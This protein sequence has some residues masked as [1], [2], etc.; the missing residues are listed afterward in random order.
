[1]KPNPVMFAHAMLLIAILACNL[2]GSQSPPSPEDKSQPEVD[3]ESASDLTGLWVGTFNETV[4][5]LRSLNATLEIQPGSGS[6]ITGTFSL[7]HPEGHVLESYTVNGIVEGNRVLFN[8]P[9]RRFFW[10]TL[11]GD[12]ITGFVAWDC[13]DCDYWGTF[14]LTRQT[15]TVS[16]PSVNEPAT[17]LVRFVGLA[18]GGTINASVDPAT[19]LPT[20]TVLIE[21]DSDLG[22]L[23]IGLDANGMMVAHVGYESTGTLPYQREIVWT[24]WAGNGEYVLTVNLLDWDATHQVLSSQAIHINVIGIPEGTATVRERF[25]Q[26]YQQNFGV[27]LSYPAFARYN[28]LFPDAV[29]DARWVSSAYIGNTLYELDLMDDG[30]VYPTTSILNSDN[31][32]FCRPSGNINMLAVIVDY[33]NTTANVAELEADLL[34]SLNRSNQRWADYSA[35]IG[36]AEPILHVDLTTVFAGPPVTS[37]QFL[38]AE[39]IRT[40]TGYDPAQFDIV[41]EIDIDTDNSAAGTY[42]GRGV[43]F[44]GGCRPSGSNFVNIGMNAETGGFQPGEGPA[45]SIFDHELIHGMG[46][47]HWWPNQYADSSSWINTVYSWDPYLFFGWTDPDGDGIIEIYDPTPYGL[48]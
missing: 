2:P 38:T 48:Q 14:E 5:D 31:G 32:S 12:R 1:M 24:P 36:L 28:K 9:D 43:S 19:G 29:D 23:S 34:F 46:W 4:G 3:A 25:I 41:T 15:G 21:S 30:S 16:E 40:I 10:G 8:E 11:D 26:L 45:G 6:A 13:Y 17:S 7:T 47:M 20:A 35:G 22:L 33:G 39:Q 27:L 37:G 44:G 18:E 42:G